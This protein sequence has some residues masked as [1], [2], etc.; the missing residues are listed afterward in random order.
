MQHTKKRKRHNQPHHPPVPP[1]KRK[2]RKI[3]IISVAVIFL[4]IFGVG[5]AFFA[6]GNNP[7]WLACGGIVGALGG[8]YFGKQIVNGLLKK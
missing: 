1:I 7:V 2:I 3:R 8:Y 6:A 5:I 4:M